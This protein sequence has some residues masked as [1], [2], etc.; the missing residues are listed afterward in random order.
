MVTVNSI[1]TCPYCTGLHGQ[2]A[3]MANT[4]VDKKAPEV[5]FATTFALEGGRGSKVTA[6]FD[7]LCGSVGK[8]K[9]LSVR[10]LCWALLWG[11]T[12]GNSINSVRGSVYALVHAH[13]HACPCAHLMRVCT[14]AE[15]HTRVHSLFRCAGSCSP[16]SCGR[17][18]RS[19]C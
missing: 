16:S 17:S 14:D 8:G 5:S 9:A 1:N 6:A 11:K 15:M 10:A 12:T 2:L 3:R 19:S 13:A 7:K 18:R 4:V